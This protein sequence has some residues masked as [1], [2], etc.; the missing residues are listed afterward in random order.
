MPIAL[1]W[2]AR[3]STLTERGIWWIQ[4]ALAGFGVYLA[5][6]GLAEI[7]G[8]WWLVFPKYIADPKVGIHFGRARGPMVQAACYGTRAG[9]LP[10]VP[11]GSGGPSSAVPDSFCCWPRCRCSPAPST[12][13]TR[14]APGGEA[15]LGLMVVLGLTLRGRWRVARA[16][17]HRRLRAAGGGG[18]LGHACWASSASNRPTRRASRPTCGAAS[19]TPPG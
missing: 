6:T 9:H 3:Q 10:A 1:Y 16:G 4:A 5:I 14:A 8:Q 7:S 13:P 11:P 17:E 2:I 12:S 18:Q 19:P 15:V